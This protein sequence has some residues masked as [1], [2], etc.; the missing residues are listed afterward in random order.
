VVLQAEQQLLVGYSKVVR[1]WFAVGRAAR[2]NLGGSMVPAA[3]VIVVKRRARLLLGR[4]I[5]GV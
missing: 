1:Y 5:V 2:V 4:L 3:V